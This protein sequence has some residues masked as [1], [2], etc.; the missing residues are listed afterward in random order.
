MYDPEHAPSWLEEKVERMRRFRAIP[1]YSITLKK[2]DGT[3]AHDGLMIEADKPWY[4]VTNLHKTAHL[5]IPIA[6]FALLE[7]PT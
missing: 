7:L 5:A 3:G 1:F 2:G 4:L 6:I